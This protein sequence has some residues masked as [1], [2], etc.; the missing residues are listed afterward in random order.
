MSPAEEAR[1]SI[2]RRHIARLL[3]ALGDVRVRLEQLEQDI[4]SLQKRYEETS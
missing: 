4:R 2:T 1:K 3:S